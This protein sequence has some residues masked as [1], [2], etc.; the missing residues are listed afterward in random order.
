MEY[1]IQGIWVLL[2][3][4][5][6]GINQVRN[7]ATQ[8]H[9]HSPD[10][11]FPIIMISLLIA[12]GAGR[13]DRVPLTECPPG[14]EIQASRHAGGWWAVRYRVPFALIVSLYGRAPEVPGTLR[15]NFYCCDETLRP[16]FGSWSPIEA[17]RPDFHR[18]EC[19]G[20]LVMA[21]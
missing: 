16:H 11:L 3:E 9:A 7:A 18:P 4:V 15:G 14:M 8:I 12:L 5:E 6:R 1:K 21:G 17:P 2:L 20:T 13:G 10:S 19:F